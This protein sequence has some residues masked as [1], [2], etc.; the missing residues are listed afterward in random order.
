VQ[1][2]QAELGAAQNI[3]CVNTTA[4]GRAAEAVAA[5]FL[6]AKGC[7]VLAQNWRTRWCEIDIVAVRGNIV[8]FVEVKYRQSAAWG[9]GLE[10]VTPKKLRQMHFA[11]EFW[12]AKHRFT[13]DYQLAAIE[14]TGEPPRV[15][16]AI[17][18]I[19]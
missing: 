13:G 12:V 18:S 7:T 8:Y 2:A 1:S 17:N 6:V 5:E 3:R 10:Y 4:I 16:R 15:V 14:L 9:T 19:E 11:A